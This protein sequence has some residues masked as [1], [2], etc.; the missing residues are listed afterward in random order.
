MFCDNRLSL[1][2]EARGLG[3]LARFSKLKEEGK[4]LKR[5]GIFFIFA[6]ENKCYDF[7]IN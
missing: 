4:I 1:T 5:V 6:G 7:A 2:A 3:T